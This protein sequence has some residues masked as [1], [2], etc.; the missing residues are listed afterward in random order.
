MRAWICCLQLWQRRKACSLRF[1]RCT[2]TGTLAQHQRSFRNRAEAPFVGA[3]IILTCDDRRR[4]GSF[5]SDD[6]SGVDALARTALEVKLEDAEYVEPDELPADVVTMNS[7]VDLLHLGN[8]QR[9]SVKLAYPWE[10]ELADNAIS[11]LD[12][13]GT[14]LLG[15]SV[16]SIVQWRDGRRAEK[17]RIEG[18]LQAQQVEWL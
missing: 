11:V 4:L 13:L 2:M 10:A 5:I 17:S 12:S 15:S 1:P 8:R 7:T 18:V 3:R 16:G 6:Q 14:A 9:E